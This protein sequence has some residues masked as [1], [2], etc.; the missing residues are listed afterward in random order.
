MRYILLP[1]MIAASTA[2]AQ[3][4]GADL[5]IGQFVAGLFFLGILAAVVAVLRRGWEDGAIYLLGAFVIAGSFW[6]AS[7]D[8][9]SGFV[10]GLIGFGFAAAFLW[11]I[12][13]AFTPHE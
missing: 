3:G 7:K 8:G 10:T 1:L 12:S 11:I 2:Y 4:D 6:A 13:G 9:V 5:T